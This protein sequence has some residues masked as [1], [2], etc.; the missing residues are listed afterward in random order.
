[1]SITKNDIKNSIING[2]TVLGIE[3]GSTRIKAVLLGENN[4]PIASGSH[5]WENSYINNIWTYSLDEV[6]TGIQESYQNMA[7]NVKEKYGVPLQTI[8]AIG[9]SAMMHGYMVFNKEGELLVP[10]RTWRNTITEKAS[11]ELTKVFNYHIPQRWSIAHLYQAILN[12]EEHVSDIDFQTT[13]EGYVHWKLTGEKVIGIGE[14]SGMFPIDIE[15]K[16]YNGKMVEQFDELIAHKKFSWKFTDIFPKVLLAGENAGVLTEE[17]ARLLDVTGNLKPG[18]PLC[19][20][21]GDAGTGMVAT[22]SIAQRT[23]NVS[24]GTSVFAMIVLEKDLTKAYE[25]IDLVTTP[26]GNLVAMVHC[27]NCTSDLNAWVGLFKEYSEAMGM[28][29]NMD[30][31]FATLYNKALEGDADCG[32]LLAYNYFS[33]EHITNFEEGRPL[34]VRT[35]ESKF[36]LSNFMR[37]HLFTSLGALKTGLDILLKEEGVKVEEMLGHGG[38]FK[39]KG[40]G[41][42]IMAAAINAPV[43]VMET[44]GEGGAWGIAVLAAYMLNKTENETLDDYLSQKVF[45]GEVVTKMYP[46]A[47]DVKGFDE[48]M[49]R[50]TNGLTIERAAVDNLK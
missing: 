43:S 21:E 11:E 34:F 46:D 19:P 32:G 28:E 29:V 26:T 17:G 38:L 36:N 14:A 25:E 49:K 44:A 27:N 16:N 7:N 4:T 48:F 39:T 24:A 8:G 15:T 10:F 42:K 3:L 9:F 13:L 33:G 37:V 50:Y 22:N 1:M 5:D 6:W 12:G 40:V 2:K 45:A 41:Q 30:K 35:P 20:P 18:I 23:G 31:L 47:K